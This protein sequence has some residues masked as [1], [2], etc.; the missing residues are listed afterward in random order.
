MAQRR[1]RFTRAARLGL[2]ALVVLIL[3]GIGAYVAI[4]AR[5]TGGYRMG[6]RFRSAAGLAPGG[7]VYFNGVNIG[8]VRRVKILPDTT[9][10]VI[11]NIYHATDIPKNAKFSI[12]PAFAGSPTV[13][14]VVPKRVARNQAPAPVPQ[15]DLLPKRVVPVDR[16]PVGTTPLSLEDVMAEG[17][18]LGDRA[19]RVLAFARPYGG[20]LIAHLQNARA[21]GAATTE[22]MR[23]AFPRILASLQSTVAKAKANA[24]SAQAVLREHNQAKLT[25]IAASFKRSA[26]DMNNVTSSLAPLKN[27][28]QV[29]AN[30]RASTADVRATTA[31]MAGLSDDMAAISKNP[32]TKAELRDAGLQFR[33]VLER[34]KSLI[35]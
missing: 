7:L 6:V 23:T 12:L 28:P 19:T 33:A 17:K 32:Q 22:E 13:T 26:S 3:A 24:A 8:N 2:A 18:A 29:R 15:S 9:V 21:N 14:I 34:L 11:L 20:R 25:A 31:T 30:L 4:K 5:G 1:I 10:D 27:D 16:Q 35:P